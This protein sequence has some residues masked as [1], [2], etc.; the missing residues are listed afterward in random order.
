[1]V[2]WI[3][4]QWLN[5]FGHKSELK[6]K[7]GLKYCFTAHNGEE[8]YTYPSDMGL[9]IP[10]LVQTQSLL[11]RLYSGISGDERDKMLTIM[12]QSIH[13]GLKDPINAAKIATMVHLMRIQQGD[14]IQRD[15]LINIAATLLIR[16][17]EDPVDINSDMHR[18][19]VDVFS[20]EIKLS[21]PHSFFLKTSLRELS[22]LMKLSPEELQQLWEENL[23]KQREIGQILDCMMSDIEYPSIA[24]LSKS[25]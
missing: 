13:A 18:H 20:E 6:Y 10:R 8:Y 24:D 4:K 19:K 5:K 21:T 3:R 23:R 14:M 17:D 1:M 25:I 12:E 11:D 7:L 2:S 9:S 15:I 22:I 16:S